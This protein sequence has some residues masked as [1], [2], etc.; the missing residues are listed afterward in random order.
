[1]RRPTVVKLGSSLVA[2]EDG[3]PRVDLLAAVAAAIS[4]RVAERDPVAV[5]SSGA[6]ALGRRK[7][8]GRRRTS[9]L[10]QLQAASALGQAELQQLWQAAF[11][12]HALHVAQVLLTASDLTE[13]RSYLNVRDALTALFDAGAVPVINENDAT[14]TDEISFGDNDVL[15]AQAAVLLRA[16][17][18]VL[19]TAVGGILAAPPEGGA[20][21]VVADGA[22]VSEA[23]LGAASPLGRGGPASKVAAA[24]LAAAGGVE[25]FVAA[26]ADLVELLAGRAAGTRFP[27]HAEG[28]SAFKLWLRYGKRTTAD[29]RVDDG[30]ATAVRDRGASLLAVGVLDWSADFRAGDGVVV[31]D[32][33]GRPLARGVAAV[34]AA[35]LAGRPRDTEVVHRDR[36]VLLRP[37]E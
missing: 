32:R 17:R 5:V 4:A 29:L 22:A 14:A 31:C 21:E 19:L 20:G 18:L 27:A 8:G 35:A 37:G 25:T 16:R 36:L 10:A 34:D 30:A 15:A 13:R 2:H 26:P 24:R 33:D 12:P 3:E 1:M 6:I 28:E 7:G 9:A 11:A 23:M